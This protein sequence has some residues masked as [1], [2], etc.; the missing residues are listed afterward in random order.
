MWDLAEGADLPLHGIL[1]SV[2]SAVSRGKAIAPGNPAGLGKETTSATGQRNGGHC[3]QP[4]KATILT[5][6]CMSLL[7][8]FDEMCLYEV[9]LN[10]C[11]DSADPLMA[12]VEVC[13][14]VFE[15]ELVIAVP[16]TSMV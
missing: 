11:C 8:H 4:G 5:A 16:V 15:A 14:L 2:T 1:S 12:L 13:G 10:V 3:D 7:L 9:T 6:Q